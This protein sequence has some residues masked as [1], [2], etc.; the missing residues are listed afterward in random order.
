MLYLST[1][2]FRRP[3]H[4]MVAAL[5]ATEAS[6]ASPRF[7]SNHLATMG[8]IPFYW[9]P[10]DGYPD[11][12]EAWGSS[13]LPRW[14]FAS[15]L[16]GGDIPAVSMDLEGAMEAAGGVGEGTQAAAINRVLTGGQ[17]P[18]AEVDAI[19]QFYDEYASSDVDVVGDAFGL[20]AAMPRFQSY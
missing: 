3:F 8:H 15:A 12:L 16:F 13:V 1:P 20:A 6:V 11:S 10:P 5:R 18:A 14:Q 2:K 19:Q 17:L 9:S 4:L 7:L